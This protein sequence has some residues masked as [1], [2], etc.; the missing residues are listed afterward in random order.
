MKQ[1]VFEHKGREYKAVISVSGYG[2]CDVSV[3]RKRWN[4]KWYQGLWEDFISFCCC[5]DTVEELRKTI[6]QYVFDKI[7]DDSKTG[8]F[9][10]EYNELENVSF[11]W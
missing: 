9:L 3:Y 2:V 5:P 4:K 1:I 11:L 7:N 8:K 6:E 10:R